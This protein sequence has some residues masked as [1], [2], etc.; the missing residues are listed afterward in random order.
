MSQNETNQ[1]QSS[2]LD[3]NINDTNDGVEYID[4][5]NFKQ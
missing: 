5:I 3:N 4:I 2:V 1:N